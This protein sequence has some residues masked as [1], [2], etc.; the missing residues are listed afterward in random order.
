MKLNLS[1]YNSGCEALLKMG[2]R[3]LVLI[4]FVKLLACGQASSLGVPVLLSLCLG[5]CL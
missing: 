4:G 1:I 5:I 3:S 2:E